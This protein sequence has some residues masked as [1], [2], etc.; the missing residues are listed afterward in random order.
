[1]TKKKKIGI[2]TFWESN[3]NYGQQLQC[4]ALQQVLIQM[5]CDPFLIRYQ[6]IT[7]KEPFKRMLKL[8]IK[9]LIA[10]VLSVTK[11]DRIGALQKNY[12]EYIEKKPYSEDF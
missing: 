1:M 4:W 7:P 2:M 6:W 9:L 5:G 11:L 12:M 3:D 8:K 10:D